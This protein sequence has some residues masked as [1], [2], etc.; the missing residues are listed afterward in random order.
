VTSIGIGDGPNDVSMLRAVDLPAVVRN[1]TGG[2]LDAA[3]P[4][5]LRID[6]VGPEGFV[7][8]VRELVK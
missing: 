2:W 5:L 7:S 1:P 8:A 6:G 4:G 3:I